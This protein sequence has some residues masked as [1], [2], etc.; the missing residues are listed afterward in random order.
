MKF[1]IDQEHID[2]YIDKSITRQLKEANPWVN[3]ID[4]HNKSISDNKEDFYKEMIKIGEE[5]QK[6]I[7][8]NRR[9]EQDGILVGANGQLIELFGN[10][11]LHDWV[12]WHIK[13][14]KKGK[15]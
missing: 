11:T 13:E 12:V 1:Y 7:D 14:Y 3:K 9:N 8:K 5:I 4:L 2:E 6:T 10:A 15:L